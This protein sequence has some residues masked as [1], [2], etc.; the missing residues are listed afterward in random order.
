MNHLNEFLPNT[1]MVSHLAAS[2]SENTIKSFSSSNPNIKQFKRTHPPNEQT[3][4]KTIHHSYSFT[5][6]NFVILN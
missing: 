5:S 1:G 6:V 2:P 3:H 4:C